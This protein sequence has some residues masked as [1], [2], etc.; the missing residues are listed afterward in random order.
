MHTQNNLKSTRKYLFFL[1]LFICNLNAE[2]LSIY[3]PKKEILNISIKDNNYVIHT[4]EKKTSNYKSLDGLKLFLPN[5]TSEYNLAILRLNSIGSIDAY[6]SM[7]KSL[8]KNNLLNVRKNQTQYYITNYKKHNQRQL[9]FLL[10]DKIIPFKKVT[11]IAFQGYNIKND[12]NKN[13]NRWVYISIFNKFDENTKLK[14]LVYSFSMKLNKKLVD[15]FV[16]KNLKIINHPNNKKLNLIYTYLT[17]FDNLNIKKLK[18]KKKANLKRFIY[19][20]DFGYLYNFNETSKINSS[21]IKL[22]NE[23]IQKNESNENFFNYINNYSNY[24]EFINELKLRAKKLENQMKND[25]IFNKDSINKRCFSNKK[26]FNSYIYHSIKTNSLPSFQVIDNYGNTEVFNDIGKY[27]FEKKQYIKSEL[28]LLK[29]FILAKEKNKSIPSYNLGV[30]YNFYN[31]EKFNKKAI[32]YL[33][34]SKLKEAYFNLAVNY[35]NGI[36]VKKD[37]EKSKEYLEKSKY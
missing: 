15:N 32:K 21:K 1:V 35:Y 23:Y 33:K 13:L 26:Y 29:S 8:I 6:L 24:L 19:M 7:S 37:I 3:N 34:L 4:K 36:G 11:S 27:L 18:K 16:N 10:D 31:T 28:Y 9:D 5:F 14:G 30:L 2:Y 12:I 22:L 20:K 17:N 25:C